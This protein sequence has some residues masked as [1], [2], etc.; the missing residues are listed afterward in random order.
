MF[1]LKLYVWVL[2]ACIQ[3]TRLKK[4]LWAIKN[5]NFFSENMS[6]SGVGKWHCLFTGGGGGL[7]PL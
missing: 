2:F 3:E 1:V 7:N 5:D 6:G 4:G